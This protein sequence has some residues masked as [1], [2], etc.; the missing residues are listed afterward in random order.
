MINDNTPLPHDNSILPFMI[1]DSALSGRVIRLGSVLDDLLNRH[2]YPDSVATLLGQFIALGAGIAT[3]LKFDGIFT[4]QA[5][6]NGPVPLMIVDIT[7]S[8]DLRGY[9]NI[10]GDIPE[11]ATCKDTLASTLMGTGHIMI[12]VDQSSIEG[13]R[14]QGVV[15]LDKDTL[16]SCI[17]EY[18]EKSAQ[19]IS[20]NRIACIKT[21][22]GWRAGCV[23][24]SKLPAEKTKRDVK[25]EQ[26]NWEEKVVLLNS[27]KDQE[28][29][30]VQLPA[31]DIIYR[32]YHTSEIKVFEIIALKDTCRCNSQRMHTAL[33]NLDKAEKKSMFE[34]QSTVE[35]VCQYC[36]TQYLFSPKD[37]GVE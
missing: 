20:V 11:L 8:G 36:S 4:L 28:L 24:I 33:N 13:G 22:T 35:I 17:K 30:D 14:Y 1:D 15:A 9:A 5:K 10:D 3:A 32:L 26:E 12:T 37:L 27:L 23:G 2:D 21:P 16:E 7:A 34:E 31:E 25:A 19:F 29:V 6:G 18:F